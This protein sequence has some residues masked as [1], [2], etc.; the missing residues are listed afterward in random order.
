MT[1]K[2]IIAAAALC[3]AM[4]A[5]PAS[6]M[7]IDNLAAV[8]PAK[9]ENVRVVCG[10]RHCWWRPGHRHYGYYGHY[11]YAPHRWGWHHW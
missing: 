7:P 5:V 11:A 9:V 8:T 2:H 10:F 1:L 6:A 4:G 3:G